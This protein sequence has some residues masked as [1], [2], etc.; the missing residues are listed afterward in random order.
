MSSRPR[1]QHEAM[2]LAR[3]AEM[4]DNFTRAQNDLL[5]ARLRVSLDQCE[6][7]QTSL[8]LTIDNLADATAEILELREDYNELVD[9][10]GYAVNLYNRS[11][12]ENL[13][14][15]NENRFFRE[16]AQ[17]YKAALLR[18]RS[19][20]QC[21]RTPSRSLQDAFDLTCSETESEDFLL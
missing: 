5:E 10:H 4:M 9:S 19:Q 6:D 11:I 17:G 20:C 15:A 1:T 16:Q 7:L 13:R 3:V 14:L 21:V 8:D 18:L 2:Q 12:A